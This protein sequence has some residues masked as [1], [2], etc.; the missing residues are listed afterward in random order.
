[1]DGIR[2]IA[3]IQ[4]G[5]TRLVSRRGWDMSKQYPSLAKELSTL[6]SHNIVLDG[7][8]IALGES[9]RPSFQHLQ[10]RLNLLKQS[11]IQRAEEMVP[12]FYFVFDLVFADSF[13]LSAVSLKNRKAILSNVLQQS[14]HVRII[15]PFDQ[16]GIIAYEACV[17]MGFEGIVAKS[18]ASTYEVGRRSQSWVK[19]KAQRTSEFVIGGYTPGQGSR[20]DTFGAMLLGYYDE[21]GRL[22]S[23][24]SVGTGFDQKILRMLLARM[25]PLKT[26]KCPFLK[27]PEDK[28][29]ALWLV[30]DMVAEIKFM[31]WTR[32]S[33][34]RNPVFIRLREDIDPRQVGREI[35]ILSPDVLIAKAEENQVSSDNDSPVAFIQSQ[36][37]K[38]KSE[39]TQ[40]APAMEYSD[41]A[42]AVAENVSQYS[43]T[44]DSGAE[45]TL[46]NAKAKR[47]TKKKHAGESHLTVVGETSPKSENGR[48]LEIIKNLDEGLILAAR[49]A[50]E[51]L[52]GKETHLELI[53]Q[54]ESL[55]VTNLNKVLW[56]ACGE[57][58][59]V[60]K[61]DYLKYLASVAHA[62]LPY[63]KGRPLTLIRCPS[64][65]KGKNFYQKHWHGPMPEYADT[66]DIDEEDEDS[67]HLVCHNFISLLWLGQN[68]VLELHAWP[69]RYDLEPDVEPESDVARKVSTLLEH[70]DFLV[71]DLDH[72]P[73]NA[74]DQSMKGME[75]SFEKSREVAFWLRET[76]DALSLK[77]YVKLSGQSGMHIFIPLVRNL[78]VDDLRSLAET[79]SQY[80]VR[81]HPDKISISLN[82]AA[83]GDR[84]FLDTGTN[85]RKRSLVSPYSTRLTEKASVSVP[86]TWEELSDCLPSQFTVFTVPERLARIG[87]LWRHVLDDKTD[88]HRLFSRT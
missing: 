27:P 51:Q 11:D 68:R 82:I 43:L 42:S 35:Q 16:D 48:P 58:P 18:L 54:G 69:V 13:S 84:V 21:S 71:F 75:E 23:C 50:V 41:L 3:F 15:Q 79:M 49:S 10:Q 4:D 28:K 70:P 46:P 77:S 81:Q 85:A 20:E 80:V 32:D 67:E 64:G 83:R 14:E 12:V 36:D 63:L 88:L 19:V 86:V 87:D 2:A 31:D 76:L 57:Q 40:I 29:D 60:T 55:R 52:G 66:I 8:I 22:I 1:M 73:E 59:A 65:L 26:N 61:R 9:G 33:H 74:A 38:T 45:E 62:M 78:H 5:Q 56:P 24:G 47:K 6:A 37:L 34:L 7:E 53:V 72:H 30:P 44:K 17:D 25:D 39:H